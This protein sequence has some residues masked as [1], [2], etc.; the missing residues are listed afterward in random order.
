MAFIINI[1][2]ELKLIKSIKIFKDRESFN[3]ETYVV[4]YGPYLLMDN[5]LFKL[6]SR[7]FI[8]WN[9]KHLVG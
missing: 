3:K 2:N 1:L 6:I 4:I 8:E 7:V 5:N 9:D